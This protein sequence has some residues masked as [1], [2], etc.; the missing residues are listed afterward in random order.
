MCGG[1]ATDVV[2]KTTGMAKV[3]A[4]YTFTLDHVRVTNL[5]AGSVVQ[6]K[7]ASSLRHKGR[8]DA[9]TVGL[10]GVAAFEVSTIAVPVA[11]KPAAGIP[12]EWAPRTVKFVLLQ[13]PKSADHRYDD[14]RA[15]VDELDNRHDRKRKQK[16]QQRRNRRSKST[17]RNGVQEEDEEGSDDDNGY[18]VLGDG[19][20]DEEDEDEQQQQGQGGRRGGL[21]ARWKERRASYKVATC[22]LQLSF[23]AEAKNQAVIVEMERADKGSDSSGRHHRNGT[24]SPLMVSANPLLAVSITAKPKE[25][26]KHK[27]NEEQ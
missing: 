21:L 15:P 17:A 2:C 18:N 14:T 3:A 10:D 12:N 5:N 20:S 8:T 23:F 27:H 11:M 16:Q 25:Q 24:I 19:D 6:L 13:M 22:S 26:H 7:W 9:I 4:P 1:A